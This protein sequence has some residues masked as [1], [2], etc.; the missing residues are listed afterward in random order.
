M[1]IIPQ[2]L[3]HIKPFLL[4]STGILPVSLWSFNG[5]VQKKEGSWTRTW[6]TSGLS[7]LLT[8]LPRCLHLCTAAHK[9]RRVKTYTQVFNLSFFPLDSGAKANWH[10]LWPPTAMN[11]EFVIKLRPLPLEGSFRDGLECSQPATS[12]G[13]RIPSC[14]KQKGYFQMVVTGTLTLRPF[15]CTRTREARC[16]P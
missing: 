13:H 16:I 2:H 1:Q 12:H 9:S 11:L 14:E 4:L 10:V 5:S 15:F 3:H 6:P 8:A 7:A